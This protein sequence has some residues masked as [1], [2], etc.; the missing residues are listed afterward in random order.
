MLS[1]TGV[2]DSL[3]SKEQFPE[4]KE[5]IPFIITE[6]LSIKHLFNSSI[7]FFHVHFDIL[8]AGCMLFASY[9]LELG[10]I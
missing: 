1:T 8:E 7:L 2:I 4:H 3:H 6:T 5:G 9:H 10:R